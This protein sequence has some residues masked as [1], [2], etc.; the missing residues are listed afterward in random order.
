[1]RLSLTF[2]TARKKLLLL[3]T[4]P[5]VFFVTFIWLQ[6]R[7]DNDAAGPVEYFDNFTELPFTLDVLNEL[8]RSSNERQFIV[9]TEKF[10]PLDRNDPV[11]VIQVHNRGQYLAALIESLRRVEGIEK[12]LVIF[13]HDIFD[14]KINSIVEKIDFCKVSI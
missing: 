5:L 8:I 14:V 3:K 1:M 4:L 2:R 7:V 13:S 11:L 10:G 6:Y 12:S 9:N